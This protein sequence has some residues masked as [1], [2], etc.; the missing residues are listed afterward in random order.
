MEKRKYLIVTEAGEILDLALRLR[1]EGNEVLF[2][3]TN[4]EYDKIG[5]GII[6]KTDDSWIHMGQGWT[7]VFDGCSRGKRQ[8]FLRSRGELVFGGTEKTDKLENERALGQ[9]LFKAAG[10]YQ[11]VSRI[12]KGDHAFDE[13]IKFVK[14]FKGRLILKQEGDSP[15]SLNHMGKFDGGE[16]MIYHL[17]ELKKSWSESAFGKVQFQL[18]EVVEG[19]EVAASAF[20]NGKDFLRDKNGKVVGYL[21]FE[22]KKLLNDDLGQT[23]GEQGTCFYGCTED[24]ILF[25]DIILKP[26]IVEVLRKLDYRGVW[27]VNCI[28]TKDGIVALEP[29]SRFGIPA[30]SYEFI[31][32]LESPAGELISACAEGKSIPISIHIGVGMVVVVS[33]KPYPVE[34]DIEDSATSL[35][36]RL[37][38]LND[39][40]PID[41]FTEEQKK[42]IHLQNFYKE[43][44]AYKVA[45]K[46]G[47]LLTVTAKGKTVLDVRESL[48]KYIENNIFISDMGYRTDI[49]KRIEDYGGA[50]KQRADKKKAEEDSV[51]K[52]KRDKELLKK[53]LYAN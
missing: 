43:D 28:K 25:R 8:D 12:F 33:S 20:F 27:D 45:T 37:W 9:Q 34:A 7:Y 6:E 48:L 24:N 15:K 39:G 38:I 5:E 40:S 26:K 42:H 16:D 31:E 4:K 22:H 23:T 41:D 30:T 2:H 29:T 51:E 10:F 44:D 46:N 52:K 14:S 53:E 35:G 13:G 17:E 36:Q 19:L 49:G 32:G 50:M 47:Y 21:N 1:S 11:P 18:M 3:V